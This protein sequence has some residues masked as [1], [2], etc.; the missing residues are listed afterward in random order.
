M[1]IIAWSRPTIYS[2]T[3]TGLM[4]RA[5]ENSKKTKQKKEWDEKFKVPHAEG[6]NFLEI[7]L[8]N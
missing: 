4:D 7:K 3:L 2:M 6:I 8:E 5:T 1:A